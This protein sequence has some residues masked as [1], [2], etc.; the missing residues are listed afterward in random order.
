MAYTL[1]F[2]F[3]QDKKNRYY[4]I[5]AM[6]DTKVDMKGNTTYISR[7]FFSFKKKS[8]RLWNRNLF[9]CFDVNECFLW[10]V[11]STV[12]SQ[13]LGLGKGGIRMAPE[14]ALGEL[15]QVLLIFIALSLPLLLCVCF[16]RSVWIK[17]VISLFHDYNFWHSCDFLCLHKVSLGCVTPFAVVNESARY[18]LRNIDSIYVCHSN[19]WILS[20]DWHSFFLKTFI[21]K[22]MCV[23]C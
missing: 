9:L 8:V 17:M 22:E 2:S 15:L 3:L 23:S 5:S 21:V 10:L 1:C 19:L 11:I 6:V 20:V 7:F 18:R 14:E 12:L 13:R 4:I 16:N